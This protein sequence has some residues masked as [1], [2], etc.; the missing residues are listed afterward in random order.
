MVLLL[1]LFGILMLPHGKPKKPGGKERLLRLR[2][3]VGEAAT[4]IM[5]T[6][7]T[8]CFQAYK[9]IFSCFLYYI[10]KQLSPRYQFSA[11]F[12]AKTL[13]DF[14]CAGAIINSLL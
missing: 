4:L 10:F 3:L 6:R 8:K 9:I 11:D 13:V 14:P 7:P 5:P 1:I 12:I 2:T